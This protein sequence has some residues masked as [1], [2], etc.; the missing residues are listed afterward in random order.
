M[1]RNC[2][3][4]SKLFRLLQRSRGDPV[5]FDALRLFGRRQ[6]PVRHDSCRSQHANANHGLHCLDYAPA[7]RPKA[8]R[9]RFCALA[10]RA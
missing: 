4:R 6:E 10:I 3:A 2:V 7:S 1:R 8:G 5:H 9:R